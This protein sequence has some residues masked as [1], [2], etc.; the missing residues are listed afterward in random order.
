[1]A[2]TDEIVRNTLI[3]LTKKSIHASPSAYAKE[4][5][6]IANSIN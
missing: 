2:K 5:C 1:V 6:A 3:S 4:Y